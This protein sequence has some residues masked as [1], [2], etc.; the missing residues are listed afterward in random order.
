MYRLY[1]GR[2]NI[3]FG[4]E[5]IYYWRYNRLRYALYW[6]CPTICSVLNVSKILIK[7]QEQ[8]AQHG[9]SRVSYSQSYRVFTITMLD[10][11]QE[12]LATC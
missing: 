2:S 6:V 7:I 1:C 10:S 11:T 12:L 8:M 3:A 9:S 4:D 5:Y